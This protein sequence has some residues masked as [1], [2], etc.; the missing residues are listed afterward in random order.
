M[1]QAILLGVIAASVLLVG[2]ASQKPN[3]YCNKE[4]TVCSC[5]QNEQICHFELAIEH[6]ITFVRYSHNSPSGTAGKPYFIN[7]DGEL[8]RITTFTDKETCN[9]TNCTQANTADG[10]YRTFIGINGRLPG[11]TLI[12]YKGQILMVDVINNLINEPTVIHWHGFVQINTPW[13]DGAG[14]ISQYPI[15]SGASFRYIVNT[16]DSGT[17][18][19]HSHSGAQRSEGAL[20]GLVVKDKAETKGYPIEHEDIPEQHTFTLLDWQ[21][22]DTA[23]RYHKRLSKQRYYP[24]S[25]IEKPP[26]VKNDFYDPTHGQDGAAEGLVPYWSGLINGMGKH[27][28]VQFKNSML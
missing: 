9:E 3:E 21:R 25:E 6:L 15:Q 5:P 10:L 11:P 13:M 18:W 20:G 27:R 28:N 7:D 2:T 24:T 1:H 12:V 26:T 17:F 19:Y 14:I 22:E 8:Q 4:M 16:T 23:M